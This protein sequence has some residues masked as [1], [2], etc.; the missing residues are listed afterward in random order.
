[1]RSRVMAVV[2]KRRLGL[3]VP[4]VSLVLPRVVSPVRLITSAVVG[5]DRNAR[6]KY[7]RDWRAKAKVQKKEAR[8]LAMLAPRRS[9]RLANKKV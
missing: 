4:T 6:A 7:M 3:G 9:P 1:M 2:D 5:V 8:A